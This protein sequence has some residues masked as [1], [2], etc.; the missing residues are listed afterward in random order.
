M[1]KKIIFDL[2]L[3]FTILG[4]IYMILINSI[5]NKNEEIINEY[6]P[7]VEISDGELRKTLVTL[8]FVDY[9][10]NMKSETRLVDSKELLR[11]PYI[12]LVGMLL[13]GPKD[14]TLKKI[15]PE[16]TRIIDAKINKKCVTVNL[17]K[18]FI[19]NADGDVNNKCK[20]IY[21]IVN[22]LTE[23]NE[24]QSVKFL[25]DGQEIEGFKE[26]SIKLVNEFAKT[27]FK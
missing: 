12:V 10:N 9:E 11:N 8:Y 21:S 13:E 5:F 1:K 22:T 20:M 18:E 15:I 25:I 19:E 14:S 2:F 24:V 17:S 27:D 3:I 26:D 16:G 6:V 4:L 7:E 23:L